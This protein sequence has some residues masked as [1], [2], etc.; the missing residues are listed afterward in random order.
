[1]RI[2]LTGAMGQVGTE[3][4]PLL[5]LL[6]ELTAVDR[7]ECDLASPD[8]IRALV[9]ETKPEIIVNP[10]AYTA[11]NEAET[12]V[13]LARAINGT[14]AGVLADE[15]H[16]RGAMF[17]H[18]STDYVFNGEKAGAYVETDEPAP[19]N[20]Y[21]ATKLEGEQAV[22]RAGGRSLVLRTS[23]VYGPHGSNF[24]LTIRKLA[25]EREELKIVADQ[26]GAPTSSGQI[27]RATAR[28]VHR[29][30]EVQQG[31]FPAGLY[32]MTAA[33][34]TSWFGFAQAIVESM[35]ERK[36]QRLLPVT[37]AEYPT[38]ARRPLN[39]LLDNGKFERTFGFRLGDWE[40]ATASVL[41]ELAVRQAA[42][43]QGATRE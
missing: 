29:Y 32:H 17:V 19:L 9:A 37:T 40:T 43:I 18:Y 27:A 36:L 24:L 35:P 7:D 41:Q 14:A 21:G 1:M 33:G 4:K 25:Q 5:G 12:Q 16:K 26:I 10:A 13:E 31:E 6:G 15:A 38:A 39:S 34:S 8:A 2:L 3:L 42:K 23:W 22:L 28:L 20:M 30:A 11:V